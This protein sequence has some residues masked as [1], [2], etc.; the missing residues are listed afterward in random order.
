MLQDKK[1]LIG[2]TGSIAAYKTILLVR[3]LVK[4]GADVK[5]V[6]T[7]S[8]KDFVSPLVL[9][10]LSKNKTISEL[11]TNDSWENHVML[12][13]WADVFLIAPLSCNTLAKMANGICDNVL[14]AIYL[15]ATCPVV[16]APAMDEDMWKHAATKRN[17]ATLK[18][19]SV[20]FIDVNNGEL[21][22]GLIGEGRMAEPEEIFTFLI[23]NF[24][25]TTE[26]VGKKIL[27]TAG[28]TIEAI[29]PVRFISNH[30]T[31]KMGFAI[32]EAFYLQ[33]A[34][35]I[36]VAGNVQVTTKYKG[37]KVVSVTSADEM[38]KA[39]LQYFKLSNIAVLSA[40]VAD[41]KPITT[42]KEKI[43]KKEQILSL[44]LI[45][46]KDILATLGNT[47]KRN[48]FVVGFALETN[49]E[50]ENALNKLKS[51]KVDVII[52]N[53]LKQKGAGFKTNTNQISIYNKNGSVINFDLK[54]KAAVANDIVK[55]IKNSI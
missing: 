25:R 13:R 26:F 14:M 43:K 21:A 22:S 36:I 23:E 31:G 10:T 6:I 50:N 15:S 27:I 33:G 18:K 51:K 47:K 30:S 3:M 41:Y 37:I 44:N 19:D 16:V 35:V 20:Q 1:I 11:S 17:M 32:A 52:L 40:A 45:K 4:A 48:Q 49:N 24:F 34:E 55:Y 39:T 46:N 53:S 28:G 2:I 38:Y 5:I 7:P 12:G 42:A 9:S 54:T 29:D 8:A